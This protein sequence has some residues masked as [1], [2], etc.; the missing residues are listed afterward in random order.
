MKIEY[1]WLIVWVLKDFHSKC[2]TNVTSQRFLMSI[3]R[4]GE[5]GGVRHPTKTLMKEG[6]FRQVWS[7]DSIKLILYWEI[8]DLRVHY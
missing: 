2:G 6:D 8:W 7:P 5:G 3:P 4:L 1:M